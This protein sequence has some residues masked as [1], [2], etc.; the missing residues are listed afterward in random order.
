MCLNV[1]VSLRDYELRYIT[2]TATDI[3]EPHRQVLYTVNATNSSEL[4]A[5]LGNLENYKL[6]V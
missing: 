4:P 1:D 5:E 6:S 2:S 3:A